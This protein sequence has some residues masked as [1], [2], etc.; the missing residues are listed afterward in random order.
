MERYVQAARDLAGEHGVPFIET[1]LSD[2]H[3]DRSELFLDPIHPTATGNRLIA[4]DVGSI[5][6]DICSETGRSECGL[7]HCARE[8]IFACGTE[9]SNG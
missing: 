5:Y 2:G 4:E 3:V 6:G 9:R 8:T 7:L 1:R